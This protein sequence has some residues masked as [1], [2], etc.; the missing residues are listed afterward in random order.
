MLRSTMKCP[1]C[2]IEMQPKSYD[3]LTIDRCFSCGGIFLDKGQLDTID[4]QNLA[5]LVDVVGASEK[6][7]LMDR[8]A[9]RCHR[10]DQEMTRLT[11]ANDVVFDWCD[12]CEG[13]FFDRGELSAMN[14]IPEDDDD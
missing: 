10:C 2:D 12:K 7:E 3:E 9:G 11:G 1:K 5:T 4:N 13:I 14:L 8:L 6:A